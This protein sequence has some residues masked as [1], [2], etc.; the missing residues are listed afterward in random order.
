MK[1]NVYVKTTPNYII[2]CIT[3]PDDNDYGFERVVEYQFRKYSYKLYLKKHRFISKSILESGF[4]EISIPSINKKAMKS[5]VYSKA[6]LTK[7]RQ[8][9]YLQGED[10]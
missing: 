5:T 1:N 3:L 8:L 7:V 6:I 9:L 10:I 4:F 2:I